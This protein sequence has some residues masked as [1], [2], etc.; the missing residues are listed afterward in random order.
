MNGI[1]TA[2]PACTFGSWWRSSEV[3][4]ARQ[5]AM[6]D[7]EIEIGEVRRHVVDIGDIERVAINGLIVR[8]LWTWMLRM[9]SSRQTSK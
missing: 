6:L 4:Q 9:P 8:P 1:A 2:S 5:T 7:D 3:L